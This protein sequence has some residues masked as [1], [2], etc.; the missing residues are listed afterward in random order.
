[1]SLY[2]LVPSRGRPESAA[3]LQDAF[4]KLCTRPDTFLI[5]VLDSDDKTLKDYKGN[6]IILQPSERRGIVDPLNRAWASLLNPAKVGFMGDDHLPKTE[7]WD[8]K[9]FDE[10]E[11]LGTGFV[12]GND[13]LMGERLPTACFMT[14]DIPKA[15][16]YMAPPQLKH[17]YV[18]DFW[19]RVGTFIESISYLP[20]VVIE[21]LHFST[22]KSDLD[23]TYKDANHPEVDRLAWESYMS[24][25]GSPGH[26]DCVKVRRLLG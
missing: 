9:I 8:Q 25:L 17:L 6:H 14:G 21:H 20:D 16:G 4:K 3:R 19:L 22:G 23:Q 11:R 26:A 1:M 7:G 12:Y 10:L 5:F 2:V 13:L 15:L 24:G 18:D